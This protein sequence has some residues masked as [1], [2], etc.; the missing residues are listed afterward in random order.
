[1][2]QTMT[3]VCVAGCNQTG[4][5]CDQF[6]VETAQSV[7]TFTHHIRQLYSWRFKWG[8]REGKGGESNAQVAKLFAGA[9]GCLLITTN[10]EK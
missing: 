4:R 5:H 6:F 8:I 1:M 10:A 3:G 9:C 2:W 7:G